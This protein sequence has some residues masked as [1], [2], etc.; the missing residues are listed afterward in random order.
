[1]PK[2]PEKKKK[3][4]EKKRANRSDQRRIGGINEAIERGLCQSKDMQK[5]K[6]QI[7]KRR[8]SEAEERSCFLQISKR[9]WSRPAVIRATPTPIHAI[10]AWNSCN[11]RKNLAPNSC[12]ISHH[13]RVYT[14]Y[15]VVLFNVE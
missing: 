15:R 1:M 3:R 2:I 8:E 9:D 6:F 4:R 10:L 5:Q 12:A 7:S 14:H 11:L 13:F